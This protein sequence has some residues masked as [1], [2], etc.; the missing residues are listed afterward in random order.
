MFKQNVQKTSATHGYD[1][2][3]QAVKISAL[4][5]HQRRHERSA[6]KKRD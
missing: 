3:N 6:G 1:D 5:K 4:E 2:G